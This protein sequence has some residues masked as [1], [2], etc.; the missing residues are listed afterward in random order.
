MSLPRP[1]KIWRI[2]GSDV[3]TLGD[4]GIFVSTGTSLHPKMTCPSMRTVRSNSCSQA[5]L[6]AL[7]FGKKTIPTPYSPS[8]GNLTPCL[9]ISVR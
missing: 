8:G 4:I 5:I 1:I 2:T 7:S 6:E 9:A 3:R